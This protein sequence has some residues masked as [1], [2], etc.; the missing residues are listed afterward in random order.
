MIA[1]EGF[2]PSGTTQL[3]PDLTHLDAALRFV[4]KFAKQCGFS[5]QDINKIEVVIEEVLVNIISYGKLKKD[6][7]ITLTISLFNDGMEIIVKDPG[8]PFNP[9]TNPKN[10]VPREYLKSKKKGGLG[11]F[12]IINLADIIRYKRSDGMNILTLIKLLTTSI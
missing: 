1:G 7:K 6:Q 5:A 2:V 8:I 12:F 3:S 9:L 10:F 4:R 11:I